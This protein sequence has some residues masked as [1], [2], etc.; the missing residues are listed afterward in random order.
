MKTINPF[1]WS[2]CVWCKHHTHNIIRKGF[3]FQIIIIINVEKCDKKR[4]KK[5]ANTRLSNFFNKK[6]S[7]KIA[8][9]V[10]CSVENGV[11]GKNVKTRKKWH[12]FCIFSTLHK[13]LLAFRNF[14][15][16][17][18][19]PAKFFKATSDSEQFSTTQLV[20][21]IDSRN[22]LRP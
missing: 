19:L 2:V 17:S 3:F 13:L 21:K 7:F 16:I 8:I 18:R 1:V 20:G 11:G 22:A 14:N 12:S 5:K 10:V 9:R 15:G 6:T 4:R